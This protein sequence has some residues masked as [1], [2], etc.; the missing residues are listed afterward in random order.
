LTGA[1]AKA[2]LKT[3][4]E[5]AGHGYLLL[6]S[7]QPGR[8]PATLRSRCQRLHIRFPEPGAIAAWLGVPAATVAAVQRSVG[9]APLRVAAA[10][11]DGGTSLFNEL[12]NNIAELSRDE[13]DPQ[14]VAQSWAKGATDIALEWLRRRLHAELRR[15]IAGAASTEVTVSDAAALHNAWRALPAR[16]LLE[17]YDRAGQLLNQLGSGLNIELALLAMLNGFVMNR[18]RS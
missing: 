12:E 10:L 7:H 4:E 8:L 17:Q 18:G 6:V 14:A 3:L 13:I 16:R 2:L 1:A 5:P 9:P 15:R 11:Q